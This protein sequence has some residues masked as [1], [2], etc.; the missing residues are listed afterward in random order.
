[1][2]ATTISHVESRQAAVVGEGYYTIGPGG[3]ELL[4]CAGRLLR[5]TDPTALHYRHLSTQFARHLQARS[6]DDV[7]LDRARGHC[8]SVND[9]VGGG[10]HCSLGG[11]EFDYIVTS[12]LASQ[13]PPAVGRAMGIALANHLEAPAAYARDAVSYVS[14]GDGS[15]NNAHFLSAIN[16]AEYAAFRGFRCPVLFAISDNDICISLK[17]RG[18]LQKHWTKKLKIPCFIADGSNMFDTWETTTRALEHVRQNTSPAVLVYGN[19]PRRFGHAATDRQ[20]AYLSQD[21]IRNA[22]ACNPLAGACAQAVSAG[23]TTY[24]QLV[25]LAKDIQQRTRQAFD[26][27]STEPKISDRADLISRAWAPLVPISTPQSDEGATPSKK[28]TKK[29]LVMR[30]CMTMVI[31]E[32]L[33]TEP[34]SVYIGED[35]EHGGYYL[36]TD[37]LKQKFPTRVRDFPPDETALVGI[38]IGFAQAGITPILEIPYAKYLD[39]GYDMFEE[40]AISHW[41]SNGQI[42]N[43]MIIRLQGFD[44]GVFGGNYHTHNEIH[45]PPGID[46]V[47]YSNGADYVRGWRYAIQQAKAGRVV[48]SVDSTNLLN[49]RHIVADDDNWRRRYP[50]KS[51][52]TSF[53]E[54]TCYGTGRQ[55]IVSY[56]N[57]VVTAMQAREQLSVPSDVMIIDSPYLTRTPAGLK[58]ALVHVDEVVFADVC[59]QGQHPFG[60]M[61]TDLQSEGR[62]PASWQC[63][64][65]LPTYNPLG[66]TTTFLNAPDIVEACNKCFSSH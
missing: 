45:I 42:T 36:V 25:A 65:A 20:S 37:G 62:L 59:K 6:L 23:A 27:A 40:S 47:C 26:I 55:A 54:V 34:T 32:I 53:E 43:G 3:E 38:A 39:C 58:E 15:V 60:G 2:Q 57:G 19:L 24:P 30:R 8:V 31:E 48:M 52:Y 51:E 66:S 10:V 14:V 22:A 61:I 12:T 1:V 28:V 41:L 4:A 33:E 46:T 29:P 9:P 50:D 21:E 5:S 35:V 63:V 49:L 11:G 44:R 64:A 7:L 13:A 16:M 56:G 18:W 17:G